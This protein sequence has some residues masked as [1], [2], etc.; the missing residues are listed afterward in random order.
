MFPQHVVS[1]EAFAKRFVELL[2]EYLPGVDTGAFEPTDRRRCWNKTLKA[3]LTVIGEEDKHLDVAAQNSTVTVLK[4]QSSLLWRRDGAPLFAM[5]TG[6][7]DRN[8]LEISLEWLEAFKCPQKLF[9]YSCNKWQDAVLDQIR[10]VLLRYPYHIAGEQYLFMNMVGADS[11]FHLL[12][13]DFD[14]SGGLS[15]GPDA[16]LRPVPGSPFSWTTKH[17]TSG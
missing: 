16:V 4:D 15:S 5:T 14:R 7:G 6:W 1:P 11:R 10:A 3:V 12:A 9:V 13:A 8:E 17:R 2:P